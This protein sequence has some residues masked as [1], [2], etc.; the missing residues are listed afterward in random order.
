MIRKVKKILKNQS[1]GMNSKVSQLESMGFD[2]TQ[3]TN[4]L[5]ASDGNLQEATHF[6]LT[7]QEA[8]NEVASN[9][10]SI[11]TPRATGNNHAGQ[12][13][14]DR[15][16]TAA[17]RFGTNRAVHR[18]KT[19]TSIKTNADAN[20]NSS[21][22]SSSSSSKKSNSIMALHP[23]VK[24]PSKMKDK[25]KEEQILRCSKRLA[26]HPLAV[27]T[28]LQA[29]MHVRDEP[30]N[31]KYR[32]VD[33]T[34][35]GFVTALKDKPGALDLFK[36]MNFTER[37]AG[38]Q[39]KDL[40]LPKNRIDPALLYLGIS[41]LEQIRKTEEYLY[42]KSLIQ[43]Q[44][45][46]T[47]I[48]NGSNLNANV[49]AEQELIKRANNLSLVPSE[50]SLGTGALLQVNLGPTKSNADNDATVTTSI[51]KIQKI[52]R[53]FDGDDTLQNIIHWIGAHG[54]HCSLLGVGLVGGWRFDRARKNGGR[55]WMPFYIVST[56]GL[57]VKRSSCLLDS[58][59]H[60]RHCALIVS[61]VFY[62]MLA[63]PYY[64]IPSYHSIDVY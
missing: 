38:T 49:D 11:A 20:L 8:V 18:T 46:I 16:K 27:D 54:R 42:K 55:S 26:A 30:Y 9:A 41:A 19:N 32:K 61:P 17:S 62:K 4:A 12:A 63:P 44:R 25:S 23:N 24:I 57:E 35:Q 34:S 13:A 3:A 15:A 7:N 6:L 40:I 36:A 53:R 1:N 50:P 10:R 29:L 47:N 64:A 45:D 14:A 56:L 31:D 39:R 59:Y 58:R 60:P 37:N 28:L 22:L 2:K 43:F 48:I 33:T 52:S 5:D 21:S 51:E